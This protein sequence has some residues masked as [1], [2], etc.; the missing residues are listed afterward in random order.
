MYEPDK[1]HKVGMVHECLDGSVTEQVRGFNKIITL[2]FKP[3][4]TP[5]QRRF[6]ASWFAAETKWI[7]YGGLTSYVVVDE[8]LVSSWLYDC[9]FNRQFVVPMRDEYIYTQW[10]DGVILDTNMYYTAIVQITGTPAVPQ[11]FTTNAVPLTTDI[12][13]NAFPV[14]DGALQKFS[15][16]GVSAKYSQFVYCQVGE[17]T[18]SSGNL[19]WQAFASDFGTPADDGN[20]WVKFTIS[21]QTTT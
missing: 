19:T 2:T 17:V 14:F 18:V 15:V 8:D 12:W 11:T 20:Y 21:V 9:E 5:T 3:V 1:L 4:T 10:A 13:G 6:L 16:W 7:H